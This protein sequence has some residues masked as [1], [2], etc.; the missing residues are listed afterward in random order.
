MPV[1]TGLDNLQTTVNPRVDIPIN[2]LSGVK[3][4]DA[5]E[6]DLTPNIKVYLKNQS[7][8]YVLISNPTTYLVDVPKTLELKYQVTDSYTQTT[9]LEKTLNVIQEA[10][11][12]PQM[13]IIPTDPAFDINHPSWSSFSLKNRTDYLKTLKVP[14]VRAMGEA[15]VRSGT[16]DMSKSEYLAKLNRRQVALNNAYGKPMGTDAEGQY[17]VP[18]TAFPDHLHEDG[19]NQVLLAKK[20]N[21]VGSVG[22]V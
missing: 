3:A 7:G 4:L 8:Q 14:E 6:V 20:N 19:C 21:G 17:I 5:K 2:L 1:F 18:N 11:I 15:M 22:L 9:E 10:L 13:Q 16:N 12:V